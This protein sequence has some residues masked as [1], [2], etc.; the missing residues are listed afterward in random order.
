MTPIF[1]LSLVAIIALVVSILFYLVQHVRRH[2]K[3]EKTETPMDD[4]VAELTIDHLAGIDRRK[5]A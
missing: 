5:T 4:S 3:V 2:D 1:A